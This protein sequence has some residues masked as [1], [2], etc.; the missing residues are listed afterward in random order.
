MIS[1]LGGREERAVWPKIAR[2]PSSSSLSRAASSGANSGH[3]LEQTN[4]H[5]PAE[6][7]EIL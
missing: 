1:V 3:S 4:K 7:V 5:S 2:R 6:V